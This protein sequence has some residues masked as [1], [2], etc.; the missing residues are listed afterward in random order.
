MYVDFG[1]EIPGRLWRRIYRKTNAVSENINTN[2]EITVQEAD[3]LRKEILEK[4][5]QR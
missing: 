3:I 4:F 1:K 2:V 5:D